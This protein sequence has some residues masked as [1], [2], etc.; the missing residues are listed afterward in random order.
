MKRRQVSLLFLMAGALILSQAS[1]A[2]QQPPK[3]PI[4]SPPQGPVG[5]LSRYC[6]NANQSFYYSLDSIITM[7]TTFLVWK[8]TYNGTTQ[9]GSTKKDMPRISFDALQEIGEISENGR[10]RKIS[11]GPLTFSFQGAE[12]VEYVICKS[13]K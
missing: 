7:A 4:V 1:N 10:Y 2:Q 8:M 5:G 11:A 12:A 6:S 13:N 9:S 3:P